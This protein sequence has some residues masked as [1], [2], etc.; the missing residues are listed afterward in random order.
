M[1]QNDYIIR[2]SRI[3]D[4]PSVLSLIIKL[5]EY[6][7]EPKEVENTIEQLT[8]DGFGPEP[9]F[10]CIVAEKQNKVIGFALYC[11]HYSTWKGNCLYLEDIY[12]EEET[13][14]IG[15]GKS[16]FQTI[17]EISKKLKVKRM[18]WQVLDW[19][20][21][22]INFYNKYEAEFVPNWL[23]VKFTYDKLQSL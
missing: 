9:K 5:A 7:K 6:E 13:R 10:K 18:M 3:E 21:S 2:D 16:L 12:V 11:F 8:E 23:N 14:G 17:I 20:E 15:I 4:M 22:A 19:N 1:N